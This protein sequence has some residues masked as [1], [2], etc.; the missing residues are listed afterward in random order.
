MFDFPIKITNKNG[1]T[2]IDIRH[3]D[4]YKDLIN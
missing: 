4:S 2:A 1:K 3:G